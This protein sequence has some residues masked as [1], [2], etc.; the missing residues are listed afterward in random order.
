[1]IGEKI[2]KLRKSRSLCGYQLAAALRI[3]PATISRWESG[4]RNPTTR[5]IVELATF[6]RVTPNDLLGIPSDHTEK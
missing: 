3:H 5:D 4:K 2:K 1:M 6:F